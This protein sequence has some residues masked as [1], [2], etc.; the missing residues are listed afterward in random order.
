MQIDFALKSSHHFLLVCTPNS[1]ASGWVKHEYQA[2]FNQFYIPSHGE[3][4]LIIMKGESFSFDILPTLFTGIQVVSEV[5]EVV[6]ALTGNDVIVEEEEI[7]VEATEVVEEEEEEVVEP[8][9]LETEESPNVVEQPKK[10]EAA[11]TQQEKSKNLKKEPLENGNQARRKKKRDLR[12]AQQNLE[13]WMGTAFL[14]TYIL[15]Y[16]Y[17]VYSIINSQNTH[18][19]EFEQMALLAPVVGL[20]M[21][22]MYYFASKNTFLILGFWLRILLYGYLCF[23]PIYLV[24]ISTNDEPVFLILSAIALIPAAITYVIRNRKKILTREQIII[25]AISYLMF[26]LMFLAPLTFLD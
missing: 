6:T 14:V 3:R 11:K 21:S 2:F 5:E 13:P 18:D 10:V 15:L 9:K 20:L 8:I 12:V 24:V 17:F 25:K 26:Y 4:R 22:T 19:K 7:Q 16:L 1:M 23:V